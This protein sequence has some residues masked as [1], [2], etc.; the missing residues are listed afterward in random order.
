MLGIG[1]DL[2]AIA[3]VV[4]G[5]TLLTGGAGGITGTVTGVLLPGVIQS[6]INQVGNLTPAVQPVV[7]GAVLALV[8]VAQ[9]VLGKAQRLS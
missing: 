1:L 7:S 4:I 8:V 9:R 5:G 6:L 2:D 3:A